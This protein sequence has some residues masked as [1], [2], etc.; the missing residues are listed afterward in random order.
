MD[1]W[2]SIAQ[3]SER[4]QRDGRPNQHFGDEQLMKLS[5]MEDE[6]FKLGNT[7]A[8]YIIIP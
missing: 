1:N 5:E 2:R 7:S 6:T 4:T 3:S 8:T